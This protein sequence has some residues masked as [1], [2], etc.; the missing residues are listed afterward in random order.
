MREKKAGKRSSTKIVHVSGERTELV[1]LAR[2]ANRLIAAYKAWHVMYI[3]RACFFF[4]FFSHLLMRHFVCVSNK[5][6]K[7]VL[8]YM[9]ER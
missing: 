7:Y 4:F 8:I 5:N 2:A 1:R 3:K 6:R 9:R